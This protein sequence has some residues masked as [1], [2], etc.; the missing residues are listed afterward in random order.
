MLSLVIENVAGAVII[1]LRI[2]K[3]IIIQDVV[4]K[5]NESLL[6]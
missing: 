5:I 3:Y 4:F 1:I 2:K 6:F